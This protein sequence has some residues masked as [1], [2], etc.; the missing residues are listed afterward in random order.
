M[1]AEDSKCDVENGIREQ[2]CTSNNHDST[3]KMNNDRSKVY[4]Y[5]LMSP[6][7]YRVSGRS[8]SWLNVIPYIYTDTGWKLVQHEK[9]R[10]MQRLAF[11]LPASSFPQISILSG[12]LTAGEW[13]HRTVYLSFHRFG[14]KNR[15]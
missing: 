4:I 3:V 12:N 6:L 2:N 9:N 11:D 14:G 15:E 1:L 5:S 13:K 8:S 10:K 7:E